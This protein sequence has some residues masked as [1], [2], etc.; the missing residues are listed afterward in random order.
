MAIQAFPAA[1]F[2]SEGFGIFKLFLCIDSDE[3]P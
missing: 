2:E 3:I 1:V